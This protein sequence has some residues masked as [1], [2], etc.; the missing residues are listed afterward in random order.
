LLAPMVKRHYS[1]PLGTDWSAEGPCVQ[2]VNLVARKRESIL[3]GSRQG[4]GKE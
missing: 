2:G 3:S 1:A 4:V